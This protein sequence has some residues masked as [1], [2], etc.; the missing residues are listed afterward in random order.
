MIVPCCVDEPVISLPV[1]VYPDVVHIPE[2]DPIVLIVQAAQANA[3]ARRMMGIRLPSPNG[4]EMFDASLHGTNH[5]SV[6]VW[7]NT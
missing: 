3:S 1:Q 4:K 7:W 5:P 2:V 6:A